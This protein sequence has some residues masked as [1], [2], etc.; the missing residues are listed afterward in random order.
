MH[1]ISS[2]LK[3]HALLVCFLYAPSKRLITIIQISLQ[4]AKT[5]SCFDEFY[6][7]NSSAF[8][9]FTWPEILIDLNGRF[10][11]VIS[12]NIIRHVNRRLLLLSKLTNLEIFCIQ[13]NF[14]VPLII[15]LLFDD[16]PRNLQFQT[17]ATHAQTIR[18]TNHLEKR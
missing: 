5:F 8:L 16:C 1:T 7:F 18:A 15:L 10:Q 2:M 11:R 9:E 3:K 12:A 4:I 13:S 6:H 17:Y 14:A